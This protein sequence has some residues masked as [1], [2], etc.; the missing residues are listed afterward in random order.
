[1]RGRQASGNSIDRWRRSDWWGVVVQCPD[2]LALATFYSELLG[3]AIWKPDE[4]DAQDAA[5]DL[6]QGVGYLSFQGD[7]DYVPPVWPNQNGEQ[8]MAMHLDFEV[9]DLAA[10]VEHAI[11]LGATLADHQPQQDLRIL[12]DPAGHPFCL[13]T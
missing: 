5:L 10:A 4:A 12:L 7:P 1:M 9:S 8:R 6:G 13:Y 3:W 2:A 11:E